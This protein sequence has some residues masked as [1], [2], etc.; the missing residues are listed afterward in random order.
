MCEQAAEAHKSKGVIQSSRRNRISS[1]S[2]QHRKSSVDAILDSS[3][4]AALSQVGISS[5]KLSCLIA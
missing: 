5:C 3:N 1:D 2:A 4:S